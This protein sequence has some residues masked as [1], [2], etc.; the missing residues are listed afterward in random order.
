MDQSPLPGLL[1][2]GL[3]LAV[4]FVLSLIG[5]AIG[6]FISYLLY[7][8]ERKL[9]EAYREISP[10]LIFLLLVP[11][12]NMVWIFFVVIKVSQSFQKFFAAQQRTDVGDCGYGIGLGWAI[13]AVCSLLPMIGII[14]ALASLVLMVLSACAT[15]GRV[16]KTFTPNHGAKTLFVSE[17]QS[18]TEARYI[19]Q[20]IRTFEKHGYEIAQDKTQAAYYLDFSITGGLVVTVEISLLRAADRRSVLNVSSTN[21]GWGTGAASTTTSRTTSMRRYARRGSRASRPT[22][23]DIAGPQE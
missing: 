18:E 15:S 16:D 8:A 7:D 22:S 12:L 5:L 1:G 6:L 23:S 2:C 11:L 17:R 20:V 3:G 10:G 13:T 14:S 9:P 19:N 4:F 21:S